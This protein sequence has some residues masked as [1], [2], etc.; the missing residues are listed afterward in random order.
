MAD[1]IV[2]FTDG[3][4]MTVCAACIADV[5]AL[6]YDMGISAAEIVSVALDN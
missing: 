3:S 5:Y 2:R 6:C 1:Y 4:E